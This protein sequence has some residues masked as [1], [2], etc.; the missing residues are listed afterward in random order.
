M[1]YSRDPLSEWFDP[2]ARR[3]LV[4]AYANR[5]G[6]TGVYV[7]QPSVRQRA[8]A[9]RLGFWDLYERDRWG[10]VRWVRAFKRSVYHNLYYYG[11]AG[12]VDFTQRR[13]GAGYAG[14][15]KAPYA[16]SMEWETGQLVQLK[17]WPS[18]RWAVRVKLQD[19]GTPA[20]NAGARAKD[21]WVG[22]E[23]QSTPA[24]RDW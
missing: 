15:S 23:L 13:A 20:H 9:A 16:A 3:L 4:R 21:R 11:R 19:G 8:A 6:W 7:G 1:P 22:T 14:G 18:R 17:G 12:H 2:A 5:D 10:E 24:D